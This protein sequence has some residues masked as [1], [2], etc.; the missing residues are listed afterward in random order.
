[1]GGQTTLSFWQLLLLSMGPAAIAAAVAI[2]A[3]MLLESR[4]R[5]TERW[6]L[7]WQKL[8]ELL[9]AMSSCDEWLEDAKDIN[10]LGKPGR[11][12]T[13]PLAKISALSTIYFPQFKAEVDHYDLAA[14]EVLIWSLDAGKRRLNGEREFTVGYEQVYTPFAKASHKLHNLITD[15][16][17]AELS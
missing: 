10:A 4:K 13:S 6:V 14:R 15:Y 5:R 12:R 3:P 17:R 1:M 11:V 2:L 8:E 7:R 16:G 9:D